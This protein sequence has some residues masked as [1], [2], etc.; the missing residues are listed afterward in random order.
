M[1]K[2]QELLNEKAV[3]DRPLQPS[4]E[5][6]YRLVEAEIDRLVEQG[7]VGPN[8]DGG[9]RVGSTSRVGDEGECVSS[10][11]L[12]EEVQGALDALV[13]DG[14]GLRDY[15]NQAIGGVV[16]SYEGVI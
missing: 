12:L 15:A 4:L 13:A 9:G 11:R 1:Y 16:V 6:L 8:T 5:D 14:T 3:F 7:L 2:T 10:E